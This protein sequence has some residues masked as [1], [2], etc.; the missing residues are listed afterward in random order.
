[1][2]QQLHSG[3]WEY[4]ERLTDDGKR[5][6]KCKLCDKRLEGHSA[7]NTKRHLRSIHGIQIFD[8]R[9]PTKVEKIE[10]K[11]DRMADEVRS[12]PSVEWVHEASRYLKL[13]N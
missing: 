7:E 10:Y 9:G 13:S 5:H 6:S 12:S 11:I 2:P 8:Q 1:M 3:A 4:F